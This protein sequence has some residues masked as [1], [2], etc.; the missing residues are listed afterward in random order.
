MST[1]T[2]QLVCFDLGNVLIDVCNDWEEAFNLA[3][4][5]PSPAMGDPNVCYQLTNLV[6]LH[7][8][9]HIETDQF[10]QQTAK[11][12]QITTAQA[13]T[14]NTVWLKKPY[15]GTDTLLEK[16]ADANVRTACLSNT[17]A[18]HWQMMNDNTPSRLPLD[19][20]DYRFASHEIGQRKPSAA[21]YEHVENT[22]AVSPA[23]ILFFDDR[24]DN[25]AA[26]TQRNWQTNI[27]NSHEDPVA[28]LTARLTGQGIL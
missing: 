5:P 2:V 4:L 3:N 24:R 28:Q 7:E 21:I 22:C 9:G 8:C 20:L 14:V 1:S 12:C 17:V 19:R 26:A 16:M 15:E 23:T 10:D 18:H 27:I 6:E 11:L 25:I 13:A